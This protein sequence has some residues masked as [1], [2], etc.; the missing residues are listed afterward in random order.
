[1]V[2]SLRWTARA[3]HGSNCSNDGKSARPRPYAFTCSISFGAMV[4]TLPARLL[5]KG[6]N[7]CG[8]SSQPKT[9]FR[10]A[11]TLRITGSP[12][13]RRQKRPRGVEGA[14]WFA[15]FCFCSAGFVTASAE[16]VAVKDFDAPGRGVNL[17][18]RGE[19]R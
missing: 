16:K 3:P 14:M 15:P 19:G 12:L 10:S 6:V 17:L 9:V 11:G 2:R 5:C 8:R 7:D 4:E 1:M 13:P 18:E